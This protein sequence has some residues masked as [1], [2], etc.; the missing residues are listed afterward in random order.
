MI[1]TEFMVNEPDR[2]IIVEFDDNVVTVR[3]YVLETDTWSHQKLQF[4]V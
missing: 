1:K 2:K 3:K 4:E